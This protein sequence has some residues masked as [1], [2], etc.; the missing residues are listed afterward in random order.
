M[1][2][3]EYQCLD[4]GARDQPGTGAAPM[5]RLVYLICRVYGIA[6]LVLGIFVPELKGF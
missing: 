2:L 3:Y 5:I 1:P 6:F 4:C